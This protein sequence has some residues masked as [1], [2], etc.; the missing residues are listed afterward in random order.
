MAASAWA[1]RGAATGTRVTFSPKVLIAL[2]RLC[3]Y[4]CGCCTFAAVPAGVN[5]VDTLVQLTRDRRAK[6]LQR[7]LRTVHH[8]TS[9]GVEAGVDQHRYV[10]EF[11]DAVLA[12][13][14]VHGARA[15]T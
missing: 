14:R 2:I 7:V 10:A 12:H 5:Q 9:G 6:E 13:Q 8:G 11:I 15:H 3:R 4:C 1:D